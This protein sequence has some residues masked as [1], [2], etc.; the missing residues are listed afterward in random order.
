METSRGKSMEVAE[1]AVDASAA[2]D[3]TELRVPLIIYQL[4]N[5][6][7]PLEITNNIILFIVDAGQ[8]LV[9]DNSTHSVGYLRIKLYSTQNISKSKQ[10]P[11]TT[12]IHTLVCRPLFLFNVSSWG[13]TLE[14]K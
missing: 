9:L 12:L 11:S 3:A 8:H 10:G 14:R 7:L 2:G 13:S 5:L 1:V 6:T 4:N